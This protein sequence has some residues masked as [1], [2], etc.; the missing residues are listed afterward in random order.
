MTWLTRLVRL[1]LSVAVAC[2][3]LCLETPPAQLTV[4]DYSQAFVEK[5]SIDLP[6]GFPAESG[7]GVVC[8]SGVFLRGCL[9]F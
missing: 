2:V 1:L 3:L 7:G 6:T 4:E 9:R 8:F 5:R